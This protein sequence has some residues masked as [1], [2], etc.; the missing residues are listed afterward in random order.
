MAEKRI[1]FAKELERMRVNYLKKPLKDIKLERPSWMQ[2]EDELNDV[3]REKHTLISEGRVYFAQVIQ[4]NQILFDRKQPKR[5]CPA[6]LLYSTSDEMNAN[7]FILGALAHK[8]FSYKDQDL[9]T[10]PEEWREAAR[11]ISDEYERT[12]LVFTINT[13]SGPV[14]IYFVTV[15][16]FRQYLPKNTLLGSTVP[17]FALPGKCR[18]ILPLPEKYWGKDFKKAWIKGEI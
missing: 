13:D 4:A 14:D 1:D 5:N 9:E 7:P 12:G 11:I 3:F 10:V 2:P 6:L 15:M 18:S 16:I 8:L 17:V